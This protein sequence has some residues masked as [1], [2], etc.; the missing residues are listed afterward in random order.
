[1]AK[2]FLNGL[3]PDPYT[4]YLAPAGMPY[5]SVPRG[6]H[7][8]AVTTMTSGALWLVAVG[9]P[10]GVSI[11]NIQFLS[12]STAAATPTHWWFGLYDQNRVQLATT[13]DQLTAAWAASA[14]KKLA[15][16]NTAAGA[17]TSYRTTYSGLY[18]LG[19]MMTATTM[20][21]MTSTTALAALQ[22]APP[23]LGGI[24]SGSQTTPPAFPFTTGVITPAST[25]LYCACGP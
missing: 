12:N 15:V 20:P 25:N 4:D 21:T 5:Q 1:M 14:I 11:G 2:S 17:A 8:S 16:A 3:I 19:F 10:G 22:A 9:I 6:N 23:I 18:Y 24:G 13:A 7:A